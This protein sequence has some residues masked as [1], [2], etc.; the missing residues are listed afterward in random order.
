M[1]GEEP[2]T[3]LSSCRISSIGTYVID[4][5]TGICMC[6]C[7]SLSLYTHTHTHTHYN[8]HVFLCIISL[9]LCQR[10]LSLERKTRVTELTE[11]KWKF[12]EKNN[13]NDD[14]DNNNNNNERPEWIES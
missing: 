11:N 7:F 2:C 13:D 5:Q 3:V 8:D 1:G 9:S 12:T 4:R 6:T 14:N 10:Y